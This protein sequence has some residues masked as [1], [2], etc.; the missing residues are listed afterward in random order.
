MSDVVTA[1]LAEFNQMLHDLACQAGQCGLIAM[2][3]GLVLGCDVISRPDVYAA[4]HQRLLRSYMMEI[5]P[6]PKRVCRP[7]FGVIAQDFLS[8]VR[9]M[10][11]HCVKS[12]G[13][14][15]DCRSTGSGIAG[16]ALV[17]ADQVIH[18]AFF[19]A[20]SHGQ[21]VQRSEMRQQ[22]PYGDPEP[23]ISCGDEPAKRGD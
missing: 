18:V 20:T 2:N 17:H 9:T 11:E 22:A 8:S 13:L 21:T 6:Y 3:N 19:N 4:I 7:N 12:I 10:H 16:S 15:E 1:R 23:D 5:D 14:G